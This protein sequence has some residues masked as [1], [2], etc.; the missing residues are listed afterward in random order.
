MRSRLGAAVVL[1][2]CS[3]TALAAR[4]LQ[5]D[6]TAP[7]QRLSPRIEKANRQRY[8][9]VQDAEAWLNPNLG[10]GA[11]GIVVISKSIPS[12]RKTVASAELRRT[13]VELP[14]EAWPYGRVVALS[15]TGV[16]ASDRNGVL[17]RHDEEAIRRNHQAA[18]KILKAL[19]VVIEFWPS[20]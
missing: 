7:R 10:I 19:G 16:R 6:T 17:D 15:D 12:G 5:G 2:I 11:D 4:P 20:A 3:A 13:L 8:K 18:I 1:T 14:V 9:S